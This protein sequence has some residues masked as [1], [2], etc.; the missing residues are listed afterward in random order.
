MLFYALV[1]PTNNKDRTD[2]MKTITFNTGRNNGEQVITASSIDGRVI[3]FKDPS[4][5]LEYTFRNNPEWFT[6]EDMEMFGDWDESSVMSWY[7]GD[8]TNR[9]EV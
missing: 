3:T 2:I 8:R 7:D 5:G 4:R 9:P 6:E 1:S